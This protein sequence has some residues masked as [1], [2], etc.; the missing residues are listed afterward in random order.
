MNEVTIMLKAIHAADLEAATEKAKSVASK[1]E[2]MR[3]N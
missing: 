3:L 2:G 1:L